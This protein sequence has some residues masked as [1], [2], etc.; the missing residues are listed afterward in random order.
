M[1]SGLIRGESVGGN[2]IK[3]GFLGDDDVFGNGGIHMR[4]IAEENLSTWM[5]LHEGAKVLLTICGRG[6]WREQW[7]RV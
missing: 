7:H 2:D 1:S 5:S 6:G 3:K 4:N